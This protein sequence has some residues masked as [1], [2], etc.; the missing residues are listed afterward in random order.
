MANMSYCR[1]QNTVSD[2]TDCHY[3]LMSNL[4][5][6]QERSEYQARLRLIQTCSFILHAAGVDHE[7]DM[8]EVEAQTNC[9]DEDESDV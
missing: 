7:L 2:L 1:F 4:D 8:T 9:E 6:K 3:N 5:P